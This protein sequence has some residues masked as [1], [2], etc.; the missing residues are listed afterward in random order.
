MENQV[1]LEDFPTAQAT[2]NVSQLTDARERAIACARVAADN[3]GRK[4]V[5]LEMKGVVRWV[6]YMVI[7]SGTSRRQIAAIAD[8]IEAA[9]RELGDT[10]IGSEGYDQGGW[11]VLDFADVIVHIFND[12]K[13]DYYQLEH[14]WA[15][16]AKVSWQRPGDQPV[17]DSEQFAEPL[18]EKFE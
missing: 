6:D 1:L 9:M 2:T 14:L 13:R 15:D 17:A 5:V 4:I 12:E 8:E 10:K 3:R 18:A 7:V 16:A 11:V